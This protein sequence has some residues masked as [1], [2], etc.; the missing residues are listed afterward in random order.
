ME[1][2]LLLGPDVA[3]VE[4]G[5]ERRLL[6]LGWVED[7]RGLGDEDIGVDVAIG[8]VRFGS[9]ELELWGGCCGT[10]LVFALSWQVKSRG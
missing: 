4:E 8:D 1:V 10:K 7:M 6:L 5:G 2:D 3:V 9:L